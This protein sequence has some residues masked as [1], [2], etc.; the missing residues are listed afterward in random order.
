MTRIT[1]RVGL[2]IIVKVHGPAS[3]TSGVPTA[4]VDCGLW[5]PDTPSTTY[6]G[7][8]CCD[9]RPPLSNGH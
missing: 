5:G 1:Y 3:S 6:G 7:H 9:A 8:V 2:Y 4:F